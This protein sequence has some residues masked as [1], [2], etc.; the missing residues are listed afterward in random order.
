MINTLYRLFRININVFWFSLLKPSE[1]S[2]AHAKL[3]SWRVTF[4]ASFVTGCY[5]GQRCHNNLPTLYQFS[6]PRGL[7]T[8]RLL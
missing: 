5:K 8:L 4:R 1:L 7:R 3:G 6:Y 2:K